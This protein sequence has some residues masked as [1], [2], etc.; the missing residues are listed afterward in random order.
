[1]FHV[2]LCRCALQFVIWALVNPNTVPVNVTMWRMY[3][4][5]KPFHVRSRTS[6]DMRHGTCLSLCTSCRY[7]QSVELIRSTYAR[8]I[9]ITDQPLSCRVYNIGDVPMSQLP[10]TTCLL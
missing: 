3:V 8:Y 6:C 4:A 1:M 5:L 9:C 10:G 7:G 2:C